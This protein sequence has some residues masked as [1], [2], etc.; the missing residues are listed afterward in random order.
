MAIELRPYEAR[1]FAALHALLREPSMVAEFDTLQSA[2]SVQGWL[3]DP[4]LDAALHTLAWDGATLVGFAAPY[5][6]T[7]REGRFAVI[8]LGVRDTHT[9]RGIGTALLERQRAG[10]TDRHPDVH[11]ISL[12]AW[13]PAPAAEGFVAHHAFERVR[14]FWLMERPRG[15]VAAPAWPDGIRLAGDENPERS[16]R[17][18]TTAYNDSFAKHY[19]STITTIDDVR[20]I[21]TRPG[22]RRDGYVLAYRDDTCVGF[23]RCE[24]YEGRGEIG[25]VGTI[26]AARGIGLGRALLRWGV[27]WLERVNAARVTLLVDGEN[28]NALRLYRSEGFEVVRTRASWSFMGAASR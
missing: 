13:L 14:T 28:D 11:E 24:Q 23:C 22:F 26:E 18:L 17:D 3:E 15:P 25:I 12:N 19:H 10:L 5:V 27:D 21:F 8:R 9:T 7:G 2:E 4:F 6:I 16:W 20:A 1:D